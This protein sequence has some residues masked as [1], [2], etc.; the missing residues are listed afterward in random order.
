MEKYIYY[1]S[2]SA[3]HYMRRPL[4]MKGVPDLGWYRDTIK[5]PGSRSG[6]IE[7]S[8]AIYYIAYIMYQID[9]LTRLQE[10]TP[11]FFMPTYVNIEFASFLVNTVSWS[12]V[13]ISIAG[14]AAILFTERVRLYS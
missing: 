7:A 9:S 3:R 2:L 1:Q 10:C 8:T 4:K 6:A 11:K 12:W 14:L 5:I 13:T